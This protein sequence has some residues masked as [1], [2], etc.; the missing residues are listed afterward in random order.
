MKKLLSTLFV[1]SV[2]CSDAQVLLSFSISSPSQFSITCFYPQ[3]TVTESSNY[4]APVTY[5][6]SGTNFYAFGSSTTFT[7]PGNY[8]VTAASAT[9]SS[10]QTLSIMV[11]TVAPTIVVTPSILAWTGQ[12]VQN[13]TCVAINPT[14]NLTHSTWSPSTPVPVQTG[15]AMTIISIFGPALIPTV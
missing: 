9:A 12:S 4:T 1:F 13:G 3:V 14:V 8:T 5:T 11:N 7:S 10:T 6:W 2:I 15:G